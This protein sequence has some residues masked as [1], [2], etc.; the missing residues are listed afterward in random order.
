MAGIAADTTSTA[1]AEG[2]VSVFEDCARAGTA[3]MQ[4]AASSIAVSDPAAATLE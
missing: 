2:I 3:V 4:D 1:L